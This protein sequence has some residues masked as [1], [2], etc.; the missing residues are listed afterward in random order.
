[1]MIRTKLP[2][3]IMIL[4]LAL[5]SF[6][7]SCEGPEGPAGAAGTAGAKGDKG[8]TGDAGIT[9]CQVCHSDNATDVNLK[10]A[11]YNLSKHGTGEVY[12]EE[13]G[14]VGC[15]GC[16]SGDGFREAVKLGK[17]DPVS[18]ATS[19]INCK[20]CHSIHK[21]YDS[22][23]WNLTFNSSYTLRFKGSAA[24]GVVD[25]KDGNLCGKCHQARTFARSAGD[26]DTITA[27]SSTAS[28]SRFGPHY[29]TPANVFAMKGLNQVGSAAYPTNNPHSVLSKGCVSCHMG[30]NAANPAAGGHTFKMTV[31]QMG[32]I[33]ECKTCHSSGIGTSKA[34][35]IKALLAEY[36]TLLIN[37][38]LLDT[39]Q[40]LG[41]EGYNVLG[42]YA[43]LSAVGKKTAIR[44]ADAD[45]LLNYLFLAKDRSN[46]AHNP[47]FMLKVAQSGVDYLKQ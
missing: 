35:Q 42:E 41:A 15:G 1:M 33:A 18:M 44:K 32:E 47:E 10:M 27:A 30:S 25:F 5:G 39:T 29:G 14:R 16:H 8:D 19:A 43:K 21:S 9:K 2:S 26:Y 46:G 4:G 40:A 3:F 45:A 23:D 7:M 11:Q 24:D 20:T 22:T 37:K 36:R 28:Y 13:A 12:L 38:G 31:A 17:D 34:T 6:L